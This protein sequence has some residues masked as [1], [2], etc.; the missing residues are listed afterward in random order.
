MKNKKLLFLSALILTFST[1]FLTGCTNNEEDVEVEREVEQEVEKNDD[2]N[3]SEVPS[4]EFIS[5]LVDSGI[6]IYGSKTCPACV[7]LVTTFGGYDAVED[8]FVFCS[9]AGKRCELEM[10]TNFV[11]EIQMNGELAEINR[12]LADFAEIT[13]CEL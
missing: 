6:V 7:D 5:C 9:D 4:A 1:L 3:L 10:Q 2:L 8:L 13:N 11:P 12:N